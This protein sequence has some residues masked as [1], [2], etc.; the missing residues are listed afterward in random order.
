MTTEVPGLLG[1]VPGPVPAE[2]GSARA[3]PVWAGETSW[4]TFGAWRDREVRT[5]RCPGGMLA[6]VGQCFASDA[7]VHGD[8]RHALEKDRLGD[9]TR[10]PGSY[11]AVVV[12]PDDVTAFVDLAGQYPL[13]FH[14]TSGRTVLGTR[15]GVTA[16]A[17]GLRQEPDVLALAAEVFCP[18][19]PLPTDAH[20]V[21]RGL[22]RVTGGQAVQV[23][24]D[25]V[26]RTWVYETLVPDR[27]RSP[28]EAAH[29]LRAALENAVRARA[30]PRLT[31]DF[32]GGLDSTSLAF[33]AA[34]Q[35]DRVLPVFTYHH[36]EAP[37]DDLSHAKRYLEHDRRLRNTVITGTR[38]SLSYQG[39]DTAAPTDLPDPGAVTQVRTRLRL[40]HIADEG[41]GVH[42]G[43]EGADALL[44]A[45]P[46]YLGD[47]ARQGALRRLNRE[48]RQLARQRK[49][50]PARVLARST[51]LSL[52]SLGRAL[53]SSANR[54]ERPVD[55]Q[56]QW[57][58]AIAWWPEPG[59]ETTWLTGPMR[60]RL[61]ELLRAGAAELTPP[62]GAG[63][64]DCAA[65]AEVRTAGMV[66]RQLDERARPFGI[67]PQAPFLDNDVIR[68]CLTLPAYQRADP[69]TRKPLLRRALSGVVPE[70]VL[71]RSTKGNYSG[72]DY[73]GVRE[74]SAELNARL[75]RTRLADLG[76]IEPGK[77]KAALSRATTGLQTPFPALNRLFAAD[78]W[79]QG[80]D[81]GAA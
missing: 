28:Q 56:V 46:G 29:A 17:A 64:G 51:E 19:I 2:A 30:A 73:K 62:A 20:S 57:L 69:A 1:V 48:C 80:I 72:E 67:W 24:R 54:F 45:A 59:A 18:G 3:E 36:P 11:L 76:L 68:A 81:G 35:R 23:R 21:Y 50:A 63:I 26:C 74:A 70:A 58:D 13:Y 34:G 47:L 9:V 41:G 60:T 79:L 65:V 5:V 55:R 66:Q 31:A 16:R 71:S 78:L 77:V 12:R 7:I 14:T 43:G 27:N 32:S 6:L 44:V 49:V 33:L 4:V 75:S 37:A 52:T 25:G 8:F 42:L 61:A 40:R 53:R 10:W 15:A 39:L 22:K 38:A